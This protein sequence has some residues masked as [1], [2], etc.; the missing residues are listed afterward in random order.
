MAEEI[1]QVRAEETAAYFNMSGQ[2]FQ[3][4]SADLE[5]WRQGTPLNEIV[6][7]IRANA[8]HREAA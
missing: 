6:D 2:A 8:G 3:V 1:R 5:R 4:P 7:F